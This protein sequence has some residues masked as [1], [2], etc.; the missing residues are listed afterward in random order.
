M[1]IFAG[2]HKNKRIIA[3]KGDLTRPTSGRLR[4]TIFNICQGYIQDANFLDLFAGSGAVGL[5][6]LSR[7]AANC[8]FVDDSR[9]SLLS[10]KAN[11]KALDEEKSSKVIFG[12]V[13]TVLR[14]LI[15]GGQK[16]GI[17][18]ADPPYEK[19]GKNEEG[20]FSYSSKILEI[21]D[22]S[23]LLVEGGYL[24]IEDARTFTPEVHVLSGL[25][26][27]SSRST[28]RS[29]LNQFKLK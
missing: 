5:E 10:I 26:F 18:F 14:N 25:T 8:T 21:V 16:F 29:S 7:G 11:L 28:G 19:I 15:K 6:A 22:S 4:E 12:D 24:F 2:K 20:R 17:I 1:H 3:P 9:E 27:V 13:F 23:S